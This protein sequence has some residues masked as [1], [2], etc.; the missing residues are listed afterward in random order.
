MLGPGVSV[1]E[2]EALQPAAQQKA[3]LYPHDSARHGQAALG[4]C[5]FRPWA[6][7][8][9]RSKDLVN[10]PLRKERHWEITEQGRS[11]YS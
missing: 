11:Y 1:G 7:W 8:Q 3:D 2:L 9:N 4:F 6:C 5:R 10:P